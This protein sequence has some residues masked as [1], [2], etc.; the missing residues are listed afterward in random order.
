MSV[1]PKGPNQRAKAGQRGWG[2][3]KRGRC[4]RR[5]ALKLERSRTGTWHWH[6]PWRKCCPANRGY[7][8]ATARTC[9]LKQDQSRI[10]LPSPPRLLTPANAKVPRQGRPG[11]ERGREGRGDRNPVGAKKKCIACIAYYW[12]SASSTRTLLPYSRRRWPDFHKYTLQC[13]TDT[14]AM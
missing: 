9:I 5:R 10:Y 7:S 6:S 12:A 2:G 11:D 8:L 13:Q 4:R 3:K 14:L 1:S